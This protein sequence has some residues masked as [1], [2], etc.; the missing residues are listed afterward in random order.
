ML[1]GIVSTNLSENARPRKKSQK[2]AHR[3][4]ATTPFTFGWYNPNVR[5]TNQIEQC[6][7]CGITMMVFKPGS[8]F[9]DVC[10]QHMM[11]ID[12]VH[13]KEKD[14]KYFYSSSGQGH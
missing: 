4:S 2:M 1:V 11:K 10:S 9:C 8:K 5:T 12:I 13:G 6:Y 14:A 7:R 3:P